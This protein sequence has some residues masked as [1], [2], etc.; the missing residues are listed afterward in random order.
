MSRM[1]WWLTHRHVQHPVLDLGGRRARGGTVGP[2]RL[3]LA[4]EEWSSLGAITGKRSGGLLDA[5]LEASPR[6]LSCITN[7]LA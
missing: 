1:S 3:E 7:V 2:L 5:S 6:L 4:E